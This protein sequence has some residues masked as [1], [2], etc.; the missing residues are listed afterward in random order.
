MET[1]HIILQKESNWQLVRGDPQPLTADRCQL[2]HTATYHPPLSIV[3]SI[4]FEFTAMYRVR[5][6]GFKILWN[7]RRNFRCLSVFIWWLKN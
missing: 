4:S 7:I 5:V 6:C 2:P 3:Q 1:R